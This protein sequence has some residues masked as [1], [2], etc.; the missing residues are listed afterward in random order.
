MDEHAIPDHLF[1]TSERRVL[2]EA[3]NALHSHPASQRLVHE[4]LSRLDSL[5]QVVHSFPSLYETTAFGAHFRGPNTL[6]EHL[7]KL[8]DVTPF[9]LPIKASLA[10]DFVLAKTHALRSLLFALESYESI[11]MNGTLTQRL[12]YE[13][14][15]AIYTMLIEDLLKNILLDP[16]VSE[17]VKRRAG[18]WLIQF[19]DNSSMLEIDDFC[20]LLESAWR[21]C[22]RMEV[23]FGTLTGSVEIYRLMKEVGDNRFVDF[24]CNIDF[25]DEEAYAFEELLFDLPF[26]D[27]ERLRVDMA[28]EGISSVSKDWV[29]K[30]LDVPET[31]L[32][33][34]VSP[35]RMY[36]SYHKRSVSAV[37]RRERQA[38]G[39]HRTAE[40]LL[41]M[42][43][44]ERA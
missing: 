18:E 15:Q 5:Y 27:L 39:P 43:V 40:M 42:Y 36:Q 4:N 9:C 38:I 10:R 12:Q 25:Q 30:H 11:D 17:T 44:L 21:A 16:R 31:A 1:D 37:T 13:V 28:D 35:D 29:A 41:L 34:V 20:P 2:A 19:W 26:E 33:R 6:L 3:L 23:D 32:E 8:A 14:D 22:T 7:V 24:L